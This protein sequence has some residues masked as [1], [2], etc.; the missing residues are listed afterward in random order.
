MFFFSLIAKGKTKKTNV[1]FSLQLVVVRPKKIWNSF[2]PSNVQL[3]ELKS[4][5][6][7]R[8]LRD[9]VIWQISS[10]VLPTDKSHDVSSFFFKKKKRKNAANS[11]CVNYLWICKLFSNCCRRVCSRRAQNLKR[12]DPKFSFAEFFFFFGRHS[13]KRLRVNLRWPVAVAF[14]RC[15]HLTCS[16]WATPR[17]A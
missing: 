15:W 11:D 1:E 13:F 10:E 3:R 12:K 8:R 2:L 4:D 5:K 17:T 6:V 9:K 7:Q 14:W 16:P